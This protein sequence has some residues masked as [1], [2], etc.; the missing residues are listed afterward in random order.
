MTTSSCR[1]LQAH[2]PTYHIHL[3]AFL[4]T[5]WRCHHPPSSWL[6]SRQK[7][8]EEIQNVHKTRCPIAFFRDSGLWQ[9]HRNK[10]L[11]NFLT[12]NKNNLV[13]DIINYETLKTLTYKN[14]K[15]WVCKTNKMESIPLKRKK[16]KFPQRAGGKTIQSNNRNYQTKTSIS[17]SFLKILTLGST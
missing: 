13:F 11:N 2:T 7:S 9:L 3:P 16:R 10:K 8:S 1:G 6:K 4:L 5:P 15:K 17:G 14:S 12:Q